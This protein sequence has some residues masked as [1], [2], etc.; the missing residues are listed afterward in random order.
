L[1]H[2]E[3]K[4]CFKVWYLGIIGLG[5][6]MSSSIFEKKIVIF[7]NSQPF[8]TIFSIQG[9]ILSIAA[10]ALT[11]PV[12]WIVYKSNWKKLHSDLFM[13][14][15][16]CFNNMLISIGLFFTSI[17]ILAG[18][19]MIIYN[20]Y[21]CD[22]Q[23]IV[24]VIPLI[25]NSYLI[26]LISIERCLLIVFN[27]KLDISVYIILSIFL[28]IVPIGFVIWGLTTVHSTVSISG[29]YATSQPE[30]SSRFY[31][32]L[33][34]LIL[35][36]LSITS[37]SISYT[38]IVIFRFRQLSRNQ[39]ELNISKQQVIQEKFS[40]IFK[41]VLIY[42]VFLSIHFGKIYMFFIDIVLNI[43]RTFIIDAISENLII[44]S[45]ISDVLLLLYMDTGI[46]KKFFIL[47]RIKIE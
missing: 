42:L 11:L 21:L 16:L 24:M 23:L 5:L 28:I 8:A 43:P 33:F 45:V 36:L 31:V 40:I 26:G 39:R 30:G 38:I 18:K 37:V 7:N 17:F 4:I 47:L 19:P 41:A 20:E 15:I 29:V 10:L 9:V 2:L 6:A 22:T 25:I 46:R 1:K 44:Y 3:T 27:I 14:S 32:L 12:L 34:Y 35:G 13:N